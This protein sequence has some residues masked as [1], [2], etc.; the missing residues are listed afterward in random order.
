MAIS[1]HLSINPQLTTHDPL[2]CFASALPTVPR[3]LK[4]KGVQPLSGS[5]R[6]RRGDSDGMPILP[7]KA[8]RST[9]HMRFDHLQESTKKPEPV[10]S[11]CAIKRKL[12][13]KLVCGGSLPP[14]LQHRCPAREG[15]SVREWCPSRRSDKTHAPDRCQ[16]SRR[17]TEKC[18]LGRWGCHSGW[19][20]PNRSRDEYCRTVDR[21]AVP[22]SR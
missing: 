10:G 15:C 4:P 20:S 8:A 22:A 6:L 17:Q 13:I 9:T 19:S 7:Q 12:S 11:G 2:H 3:P 18:P 5:D 16:T 14:V 21:C 1:Q